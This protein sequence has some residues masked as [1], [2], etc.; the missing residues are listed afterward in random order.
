[1]AAFPT[2]GANF[3]HRWSSED[4]SGYPGSILFKQYITNVIMQPFSRHERGGGQRVEMHAR[5]VEMYLVLMVGRFRRALY[6]KV[7][8]P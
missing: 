7:I 5:T 6:M 3:Q 8:T 1:M 2:V 4:L